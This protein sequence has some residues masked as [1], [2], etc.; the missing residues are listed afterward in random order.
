MA[1]PI[2]ALKGRG[3]GVAVITADGGAMAIQRQALRSMA[4]PLLFY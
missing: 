4:T 1:I 2:T 3:G